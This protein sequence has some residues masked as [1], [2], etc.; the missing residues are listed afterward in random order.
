MNTTI[1]HMLELIGKCSDCRFYKDEK[2]GLELPLE[3]EEQDKGT[4]YYFIRRKNGKKEK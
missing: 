1:P 4:C 2:C 3:K